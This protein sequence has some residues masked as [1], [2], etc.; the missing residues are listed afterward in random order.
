MHNEGS[1][2]LNTLFRV[3]TCK[4]LLC[5]PMIGCRC[6]REVLFHRTPPFLAAAATIFRRHFYVLCS[7]PL[8]MFLHA[9]LHQIPR[10]WRPPPA[11]VCCAFT[12]N[13]G[14]DFFKKWQV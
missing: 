6:I 12:F 11:Y 14:N 9:P 3:A 2:I 1:K 5:G 10:L 7:R 4:L 8:L 13:A